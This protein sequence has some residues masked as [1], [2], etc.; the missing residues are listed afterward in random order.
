MFCGESGRLPQSSLYPTPAGVP[1]QAGVPDQSADKLKRM[2]VRGKY[3]LME[4]NLG[5]RGKASICRVANRDLNSVVV[6]RTCLGFFSA[7]NIAVAPWQMAYAY[8]SR[9]PNE[10]VRGKGQARKARKVQVCLRA[11]SQIKASHAAR[12]TRHRFTMF[13]SHLYPASLTL[14]SPPLRPLHVH[15][16]VVLSPW[17]LSSSP[18][19]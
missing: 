9:G 12:Q 1:G 13:G 17:L 4:P 8:G 2:W 3:P 6:I 7:S 18:S 14:L 19:C 5:A 15:T 11:A 10:E 16:V